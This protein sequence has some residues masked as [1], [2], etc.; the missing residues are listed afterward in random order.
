MISYV[1]EGCT[2]EPPALPGNDM[3][4]DLFCRVGRQGVQVGGKAG[5]GHFYI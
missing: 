3:G 1:R 5:P 2:V 4:K